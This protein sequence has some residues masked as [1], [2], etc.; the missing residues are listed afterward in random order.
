MELNIERINY[1]CSNCNYKFSRKADRKFIRCPYCGKENTV[2][3]NTA[4][5]ASK[6][7]DEVAS[8]ETNLGEK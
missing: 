6:L 5:F 7:I 4:D 8:Y 1:I 2:K 3:E